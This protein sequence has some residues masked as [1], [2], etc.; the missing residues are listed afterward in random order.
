MSTVAEIEAVIRGLKNGKAA[1]E[2]CLPPEL[3]KFSPETSC[4]WLHR[5]TAGIWESEVIPADWRWA[6]LVP[7]LEEGDNRL[8][9]KYRGIS[10][11]DIMAKVFISVLL[12]RFQSV[13]DQRTC[14]IQSGFHPGRSCIDHIFNVRRTLEVRHRYQQSTVVCFVDFAAA[15]DSVDRR[16]L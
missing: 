5:V 10:V 11:L 1:G 4:L 8:C 13:R 15:F 16:T 6:I 14:P 2:D 12:R 3:F 9:A 7:F